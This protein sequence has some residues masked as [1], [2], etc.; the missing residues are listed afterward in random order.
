MNT[1]RKKAVTICLGA[2]MTMMMLSGCGSEQAQQTEQEA[3][4]A[5]NTEVLAFTDFD[6][7]VHIGG[8]TQAVSTV[9]VIPKVASLE[10]ITSVQVKVGDTV[11]AGQVLAT[12]KGE[13][14]RLQYDATKLQYDDAVRTLDR[15]QALYDAGAIAKSDF[16]QAQLGVQGLE[17]NLKGMEISLNGLTV[18]APIGGTVT[19]VNGEVGGYATASSAMFEIAD[20]TEL[21]VK[22]GVNENVVQ[23]IQVG[24][25][26][27]IEIPTAATTHHY[28]GTIKEIGRVMTQGT[29]TY[30][31]TISVDNTQGEL[32]AGMYANVGLTTDT[33]AQGII[34]PVDAIG[35]HDGEAYVMTVEDG[36]AVEKRITTG[37]NDGN[38]YEITEG[39]AI[40]DELIVKGN[41]DL[42]SG[43]PVVVVDGNGLP[44]ADNAQANETN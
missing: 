43:E 7:V 26:A 28:L 2:A 21:E 41:V 37:V 12:L 24:D 5:V 13:S 35:Y 14:V 8:T 30:P 6:R 1:I 36:K 23:K 27:Q 31:I 33:I 18:T 34:I 44:K 32:L 29:K 20:I 19:M 9:M 17:S 39:L 4:T 3:R 40:G 10:E 15:M 42:V 25:A 11:K 38:F 16:E 22:V